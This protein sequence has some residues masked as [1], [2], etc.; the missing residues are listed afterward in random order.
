MSLDAVIPEEFNEIFVCRAGVILHIAGLFKVA[1]EIITNS[2][3]NL[4]LHVGFLPIG[5][6]GIL[7]SGSRV[8]FWPGQFCIEMNHQHESGGD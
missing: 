5:K 4:D 6:K 1:E 2:T 3:T 7:K 8:V